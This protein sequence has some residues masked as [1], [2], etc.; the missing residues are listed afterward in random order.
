[1]KNQKHLFSLDE[2]SIY[3][4]GAYMSPQLKT[5]AAIGIEN[6]T[7]KNIPN[8]ITRDHFFSEKKVKPHH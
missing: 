7:K 2:N 6:L 5:V 1:M 3:L 8:L 4:N